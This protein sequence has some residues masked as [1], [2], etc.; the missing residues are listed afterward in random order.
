MKKHLLFPAL[1]IAGI[2]TIS[3]CKK[4]K[5]KDP[6]AI[7]PAIQKCMVDYIISENDSTRSTYDS[8]NRIIKFQTFDKTNNDS[9][10]YLLVDY[11]TDKI[12]QSGFNQNSDLIFKTEF[13]LNSNKNAQYAVNFDESNASNNDTTWFTYNG[14]QQLTRKVTKNSQVI[15]FDIITYDTIWYSYTGNNLT[16]VESKTNDGPIETTTY[17]YG[18]DNA[19][20]EF[21]APEQYYITN[22]LGKASEKL[23]ISMTEGST[24]ENYIYEFNSDNFVT[25][26]ITKIGGTTEEDSRYYYTC[27]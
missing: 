18:S 19:K 7:N 9:K 16:K 27:K 20:T 14:D 2:A 3:S 10:G 22:L 15:I 23:P 24:T 26:A 11:T 4:D 21:L 6:D 13:K 12:T 17:S 8:E 25:R 5:D 1:L